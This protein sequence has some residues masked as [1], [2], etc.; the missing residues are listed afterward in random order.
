LNHITRLGV[1][2]HH[3]NSSKFVAESVSNKAQ[4]TRGQTIEEQ[5]LMYLAMGMNLTPFMADWQ[6]LSWNGA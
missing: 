5:H 6:K 1:R 4:E 3:I 2:R